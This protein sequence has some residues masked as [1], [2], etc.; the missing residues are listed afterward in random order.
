MENLL[1]LE[2]LGWLFTVITL[3]L[4]GKGAI[5]KVVGSAEMVGN[6]TYM[7]LSDYRVTVGVVE[8]L[9]LA[10]LVTPGLTLYGAVLIACTMSAAVAL[11]LSLMGGVKVSAPIIVGVL[12]LLS[13][14]LRTL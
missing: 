7:K 1:T 4:L 14:V 13:H 10:L 9:G 5:G 3:V 11:H 8:L 2:M 6:F 12:A